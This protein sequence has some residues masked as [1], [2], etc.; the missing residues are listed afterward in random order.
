M[1]IKL[2]PNGQYYVC[3]RRKGSSNHKGKYQDKTMSSV[4]LIKYA[5]HPNRG[6]ILLGCISVPFE[7]VGK[8]IKLKIEVIEDG[9]A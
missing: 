6:Q 3:R 9:T 5:N 4:F 2:F 8:R 7:L 1:I